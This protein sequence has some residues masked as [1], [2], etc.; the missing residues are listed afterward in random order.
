M[1]D[2]N[3]TTTEQIENRKLVIYQAFVRHFGNKNTTNKFYGSIEEN[4][5]GKFNDINE[6]ALKELKNLGVNYIWYTGV[7][8]HATMTDYTQYGIKADDPDIVKG[9]AGSPYAI[10]DY[11]D[12][13]PDLA[14]DVKNRMAEYESL[15]KRTHG[16]GL[17][18]LMD[19]IPNHVARTY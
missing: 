10:K 12:V 5:S 16:E 6:K 2:Q 9:R 13:D 14:V 8:E 19:F 17:K 11:Y 3:Q 7:I 1:L 4:G 18:V 15:I